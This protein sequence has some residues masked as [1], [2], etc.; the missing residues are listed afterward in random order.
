MTRIKICGLTR[1]ED[2]LKA[3]ELGADFL[4]FI[5]VE[6]SPRFVTPERAGEIAA[7]VR[8]RHGERAPKVTGVF[9]DHGVDYIRE[10]AA[11]ATLDLVQLHGNESD[12]DI[13]ALGI[14]AV[15]TLR[16]S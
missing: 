11:A 8:E 12:E 13:A 10:V 7:A 4:G 3:A 15:K 5:F 2:A 16:V 14:P 9:Y 6:S 1:E